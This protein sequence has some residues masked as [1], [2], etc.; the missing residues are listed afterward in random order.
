MTVVCGPVIAA[1]A[2][3]LRSHRHPLRHRATVPPWPSRR[4]V[5]TG[6]Q[7]AA[8][9]PAPHRR[10]E[11]ASGV[12]A[13]TAHAVT[14]DRAARNPPAPT[15]LRRGLDGEQ[16]QLNP[17]SEATGIHFVRPRISTSTS[18]R[19]RRMAV[20]AINA[21]R[22]AGSDASSSRPCGPREPWPEST[23]AISRGLSPPSSITD[24]ASFS[25][26]PAAGAD[27]ATDAAMAAP[28]AAIKQISDSAAEWIATTGRPAP[29][30]S[31]SGGLA[32]KSPGPAL[33]RPPRID[34]I[35]DD[36]GGAR[37]PWAF[38]RSVEG[39]TAPTRRCLSPTSH[40]EGTA[41]G[42]AR[43]VM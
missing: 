24:A 26:L 31:G 1:I 27:D 11:R 36:L 37:A 43:A 19:A 2:T 3:G 42:S 23:D 32:K 17:W 25:Q 4:P 29:W 8:A 30:L 40:R 39:L 16:R 7:L 28:L 22:K 20:R 35:V 12:A 41:G 18:R 9:S 5:G 6:Q 34:L 14:H 38:V 15:M 21:S 33:F 13:A 10:R